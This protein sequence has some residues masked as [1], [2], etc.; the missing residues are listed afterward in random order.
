[1]NT[2]FLTPKMRTHDALNDFR[3]FK[4]YI[5]SHAVIMIFQYESYL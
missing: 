2:S 3:Y 1:M 5:I 4:W